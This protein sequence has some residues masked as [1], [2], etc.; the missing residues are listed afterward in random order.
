M[1]IGQFIYVG[2]KVVFIVGNV[3][4]VGE[5][6]EGI[7]VINVEEKIGDCGIFGCIFGN[8]IIIIGYNFDEG[9]ICIKFF[10]GFKKVVY[11][12]FCGMIGIVVGGGCIDKFFLSMYF[13][14]N[15]WVLVIMVLMFYRGFLC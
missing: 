13:F 11:F 2:K 10:F 1:Y 8:Y 3:F 5:M 6:F 14:V 4:F 15:W 9:K 7:V 12:S